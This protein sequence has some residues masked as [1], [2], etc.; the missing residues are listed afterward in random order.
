MVVEVLLLVGTLLKV[1]TKYGYL[2]TLLSVRT[3]LGF[4]GLPQPH[5]LT[6]QARHHSTAKETTLQPVSGKYLEYEYR[7]VSNDRCCS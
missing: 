6:P 2:S 4:L 1:L 5:G 7:K 3:F